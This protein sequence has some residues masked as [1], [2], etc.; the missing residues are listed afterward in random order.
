METLE[1][2]Q[3][4][5]ENATELFT[6]HIKS[7][8]GTIDELY[9]SSELIDI[10]AYFLTQVYAGRLGF[11]LQKNEGISCEVYFTTDIK[12]REHPKPVMLFSFDEMHTI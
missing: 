9:F 1:Q 5:I 11:S 4:R 8:F 2:R 6:A 12:Y 10:R 3:N 7:S